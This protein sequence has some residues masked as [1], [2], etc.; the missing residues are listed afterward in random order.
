MV[1]VKLNLN[2]EAL[3]N[4]FGKTYNIKMYKTVMYNLQSNVL[5]Y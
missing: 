3:F 2:N 4:E 1:V 5:K